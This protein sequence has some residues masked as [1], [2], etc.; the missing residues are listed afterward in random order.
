MAPKG[1]ERRTMPRFLAAAPINY[2]EGEVEREEDLSLDEFQA[3]LSGAETVDISLSG[4]RIRTEKPLPKRAELTFDLQLDDVIQS[5]RGQINWNKRAD[6][7]YHVGIEFTDVDPMAID[8]IRL[9]LRSI[10]APPAP[11]TD[12]EAWP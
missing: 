11:G 8:G 6:G 10:N 7:G 2:A 1:K 12:P 5:F 3:Q 9:Y 4:C